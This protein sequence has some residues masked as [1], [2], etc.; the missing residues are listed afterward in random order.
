VVVTLN[1]QLPPPLERNADSAELAAA[2]REFS[3]SL[4]KQQPKAPP[5][6]P[7]IVIHIAGS[8]GKPSIKKTIVSKRDEHG[9]ILE[10][11]STEEEG[12]ASGS[13]S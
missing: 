2:L 6:I 10:T 8:N 11:V 3:A 5:E 1:N 9:H 4:E 12:G 7:P 13:Q